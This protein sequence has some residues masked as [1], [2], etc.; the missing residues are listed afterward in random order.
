MCSKD[1][2]VLL[3]LNDNTEVSVH[4]HGATIIS[5]KC[6][7]QEILFVSK[8]AVFDNKKAIRGGIP[9]VFPC[10]G[11]WENGPQHGF[12]R[13][14]RWKKENEPKQG[15]ERA[16][17]SFSL[18]ED[19]E[20]RKMWDFRF[21][22]V[23]NV[24]VGENDLKLTLTVNNSDS[25]TFDFTT[26]MHTY[27]RCSDIADIKIQG[28]E[29]LQYN[30]KVAG[31]IVST[32]ERKTVSVD[33]NY[34]RVYM[35]CGNDKVKV[36]SVG[37]GKTSVSLLLSSLPDVVVWNPWEEKAKSMSDFGDEEYKTMVCVE[38]GAVSQSVSAPAGGSV[39]FSQTLRI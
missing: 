20:T 31:G 38:A 29:G 13:I 25:K 27:L 30:D 1:E 37:D 16:S 35:K 5:W 32:E 22:L 34:D 17:V 12:A 15:G 39:Q 18:E 14:K 36:E 3:R 11:P 21:K 28:L 19:E 8:N 33:K 23:Y 9:L 6:K 4:L 10:F 24:D 2:V 26:L 7:G